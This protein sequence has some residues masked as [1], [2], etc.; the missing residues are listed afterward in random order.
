MI[1]HTV[2]EYILKTILVGDS[3][4]GKTSFLNLLQNNICLKTNTTLGV[5]FANLYFNIND[6]CI[7]MNVWDTAGQ[8][9]FITIVRSYFRNICGIILMFDVS[10]PETFVNLKK[11][12]NI[13]EYENICSH[14]HPILLIGNKNDLINN[15]DNNQLNKFI[16]KYNVIY[17]EISCKKQT[18]LEESMT[19]FI[20]T[21]FKTLNVNDCNGMMTCQDSFRSSF[22]LKYNDDDDNDDNDDDD[23]KW[24]NASK[25]CILS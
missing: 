2:P 12:M 6:T 11:W 7:K 13:I 20:G 9:R 17:R 21:I 5:D 1:P 16:S 19:L 4:V 3:K 15:I 23:K 24:Y 14:K 10:K 8:E 25:C 18:P 22:S